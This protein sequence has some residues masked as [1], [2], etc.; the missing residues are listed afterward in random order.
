MSEQTFPL[1]WPEGW[2]RTPTYNRKRGSQF[3][4]AGGHPTFAKARERLADELR[5]LGAEHVVVSTNHKPDRHGVPVEAKRKPDDDGVAVY[6]ML[7]KR[8]LAMARDA[9]D[10]AA[11][12]MTSLA[13]AIEALRQLERHGGGTMSERAFAGFAAI[14]PPGGPSWWEVLGVSRLADA[15]VIREAHRR[16]VQL[17]H[18][19]RAGGSDQ[20]MAE[21]NAAR[22]AALKENSQ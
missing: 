15:A 4:G 17:H 1:Q 13:L 14:A 2:K 22:D 5:R 8:Q 18:P 10:N 16:L 9:Y 3:G 20:K 12:N 6:F 21:I 11:A 7:K 19:D